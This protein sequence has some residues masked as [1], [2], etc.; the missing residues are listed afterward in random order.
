MA[1][2]TDVATINPTRRVKKGELVP[3][4]EMAALPLSGRD[5]SAS[6][7]ETRIAKA[8]GSHFMNGDTLL[9]RIT[10]CL[11]NGKTAQVRALADG[12]VGEGSTE[13]IVLCGQDSADND[14]VYYLCREPDFRKFAI[15]RM[16]GTSGRQRVAWQAIAEY[17]IELP[18]PEIRRD[19]AGFLAILDDRIESLRQTSATLE[20]I[21]AGREPSAPHA[22][23]R[24]RF[25]CL[26]VVRHVHLGLLSRS[27]DALNDNAP[28][29]VCTRQIPDISMPTLCAVT[30]TAAAQ[31][32]A[33]LRFARLSGSG[34]PAGAR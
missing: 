5:I 25:I 9:A 13:F 1:K 33:N 31:K 15:S 29:W 24:E 3:F 19:A 11:E 30:N 4:V 26:I 32:Q 8:A 17:P 21:A 20:A 18:S 28:C 16:E 14:F 34:F 2:L 7:V 10:P 6:D 12:V 23:R 27:H 22:Q